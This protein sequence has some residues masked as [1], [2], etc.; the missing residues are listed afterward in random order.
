[1]VFDSLEYERERIQKKSVQKN[2]KLIA[3]KFAR[4]LCKQLIPYLKTSPISVLKLANF[5]LKM[6]N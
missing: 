6:Q 4:I 5:L 3:L 2:P 1:L